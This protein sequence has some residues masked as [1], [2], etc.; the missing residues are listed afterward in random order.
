MRRPQRCIHEIHVGPSQHVV[1]SGV[2]IAVEKVFRVHPKRA[3]KGVVRRGWRLAKA[4]LPIGRDFTNSNKF[5]ALRVVGV[6]G[7]HSSD[8]C[9]GSLGISGVRRTHGNR[10]GVRLAPEFCNAC[11]ADVS[12]LSRRHDLHFPIHAEGSDK[13]SSP[14]E[15]MASQVTSASSHDIGSHRTAYECVKPY[16]FRHV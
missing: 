15:G 6:Y 1:A 13:T 11:S 8:T 10:L 2:A 7:W 4:H 12:S 9:R 5:D 3:S 16:H 14:C